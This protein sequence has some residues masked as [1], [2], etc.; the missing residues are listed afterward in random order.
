MDEALGFLLDPVI[1]KT[2]DNLKAAEAT[3]AKE[4]A[5]LDKIKKRFDDVLAQEAINLIA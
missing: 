3:L 5:E 2:S 1:A 4:Q